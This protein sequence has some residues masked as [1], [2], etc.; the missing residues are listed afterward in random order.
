M[1]TYSS[2]YELI[3][4][5]IKTQDKDLA[6][7]DFWIQES[8]EDLPKL[9]TSTGEEIKFCFVGKYQIKEDVVSVYLKQG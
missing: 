2:K 6:A 8:E 9:Y 4:A 5:L 3:Q 1:N 7:S